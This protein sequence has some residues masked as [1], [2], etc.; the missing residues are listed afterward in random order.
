[1]LDMN[2]QLKDAY[3]NVI[4]NMLIEMIT[5][6][7]QIGWTHSEPPAWDTRLLSSIVSATCRITNQKVFLF[8]KKLCL[9]KKLN[10]KFLFYFQEDYFCKN[11]NIKSMSIQ[12]NREGMS[13][14]S[15]GVGG[16]HPTYSTWVNSSKFSINIPELT[17]MWCRYFH[18]LFKT[19]IR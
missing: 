6:V 15:S 8:R 7:V 16:D 1:M 5:L 2:R 10:H 12:Y 3:H 13:K 14:L 18:I 17:S 9:K 4:I 11:I 19:E